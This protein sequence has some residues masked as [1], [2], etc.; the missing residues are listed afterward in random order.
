MC[1][2]YQPS[3]AQEPAPGQFKSVVFTAPALTCK[4]AHIDKYIYIYIYMEREGERE[5]VYIYI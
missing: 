1:L 4:Y 3:I 5:Y 2:A